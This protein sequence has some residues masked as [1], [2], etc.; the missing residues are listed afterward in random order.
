MCRGELLFL[1]LQAGYCAFLCLAL[2]MQRLQRLMLMILIGTQGGELIRLQL[3][4][5]LQ[6]S[7]LLLERGIG[8][9]LLRCAWRRAAGGAA[10]CLDLI[11]EALTLAL[12][13]GNRGFLS[14]PLL[15]DGREPA[16]LGI[17]LDMQCG[18]FGTA[19]INLLLQQSQL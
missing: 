16:L 17:L 6:V 10:R 15:L 8:S 11:R 3:Y 18:E 9:L 5:R 12:Q 7:R 14:L 2:L 1:R 19:L 13:L 4:L